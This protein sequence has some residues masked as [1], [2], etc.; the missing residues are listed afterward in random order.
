MLKQKRLSSKMVYIVLA[1][2]AIYILLTCL[3]G[4]MV[5]KDIDLYKAWKSQFSANVTISDY[6]AVNVMN[7]FQNSLIPAGYAIHL[8]FASKKMGLLKIAYWVWGLLLFYLLIMHFIKFQMTNPLYLLRS[9]S[10]IGIFIL[11]CNISYS[12]RNPA[13]NRKEFL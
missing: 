5:T 7:L 13:K 11:H 6:A 3:E 4:L 12:A 10:L 1:T 2:V 8:Y 9:I